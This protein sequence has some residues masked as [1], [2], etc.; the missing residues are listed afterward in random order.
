MNI[1]NYINQHS[2]PRLL[3]LNY[4]FNAP[5]DARSTANAF[6]KRN[7]RANTPEQANH[8]YIMNNMVKFRYATDAYYEYYG[9]DHALEYH[10]VTNVISNCGVMVHVV[11]LNG[12]DY[13]Y[14]ISSGYLSGCIVCC[15]YFRDKL[16]FV[17]EGGDVTYTEQN[18]RGETIVY[19]SENPFPMYK[20]C[21]DIIHALKVIEPQLFARCYESTQGYKCTPTQAIFSLAGMLHLANGLV[22]GSIAYPAK[23]R[24]A[25]M[26]SYNKIRCMNYYARSKNN[27]AQVLCIADLNNVSACV[28]AH[29]SPSMTKLHGMTWHIRRNDLQITH[30]E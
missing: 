22:Y 13:K 14:M 19:D 28:S 1:T 11:D 16:I 12:L 27:T 4:I 30:G 18:E 2:Y 9:A 17:H 5:I 8:G 24:Y 3:D 20:R 29:D 21:N 6:F 7:S 15:L 23:E 25:L 26:T 10:I